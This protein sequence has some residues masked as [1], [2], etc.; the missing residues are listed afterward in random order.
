MKGFGRLVYTRKEVRWLVENYQK[1]IFPSPI[2]KPV[3]CIRFAD[4]KQHYVLLPQSTR[5]ILWLCG[6]CGMDQITVGFMTGLHRN[7]VSRQY[8]EGIKSLCALMNGVTAE[9][10]YH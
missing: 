4:M 9:E 6:V 10:V 5:D 8:T 3:E 2:D 1:S 7:T